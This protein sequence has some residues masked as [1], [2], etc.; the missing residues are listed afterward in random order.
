MDAHVILDGQ[1]NDLVFNN[2]GPAPYTPTWR[3][4]IWADT[5]GDGVGDAWNYM[6]PG[7]NTGSAG[8][9]SAWGPEVQ[10]ANA[11]L[12]AN[13]TGVLWI[14]KV[15]HGSTGL[16]QD[17]GQL[18]WS[19]QSTGEMFDLATASAEAARHNLDGTAYAF[20]AWDLAGF[21]QGETDA[22][23]PAK[24]AA[25]AT[26]VRAFIGE[27]RTAWRVDQFVVARITDSA[28]LPYS[29]AVREA[30]WNLDNGDAPLADVHTFKTIG[31]GMQADGLHYDASGAVALG[32]GF[33]DHAIWP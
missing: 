12:A 5:D 1:S 31:F 16:S 17:A 18:D 29:Q 2:T 19:P 13:P 10:L 7:V 11:W 24:A 23:D 26:N 30:Q 27:A 6:L 8:A 4:Q 9:P 22:T 21:M 15:A 20:S 28:A 14:D 33:F 32:Q 25:Y 3:V